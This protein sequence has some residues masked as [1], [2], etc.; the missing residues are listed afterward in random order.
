MT[1]SKHSESAKLCQDYS[2]QSCEHAVK[3][4]RSKT[5][6]LIVLVA[7]LTV[8][9]YPFSISFASTVSTKWQLLPILNLLNVHTCYRVLLVLEY[10][11]THHIL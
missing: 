10:M 7:F 8:A 5:N 3:T 11:F 2:L 9:Q 4:P 6:S 1:T